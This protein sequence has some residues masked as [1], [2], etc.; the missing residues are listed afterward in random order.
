MSHKSREEFTDILTEWR[1][2][3][4]KR[5]P[6]VI[7]TDVVS[8]GR[9]SMAPFVSATLERT[10]ALIDAGHG[11]GL[12]ASITADCRG[13]LSAGCHDDTMTFTVMITRPVDDGDVVP[14]EVTP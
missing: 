3:A 2:M 5:S 9:Y 11:G 1:T 4:A 7:R 6:L 14:V 13:H 10:Y 12:M 8:G